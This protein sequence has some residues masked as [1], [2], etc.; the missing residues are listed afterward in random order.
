MHWPV[1]FRPARVVTAPVM[2]PPCL[3]RAPMCRVVFP[4]ATRT[5]V[6]LTDYVVLRKF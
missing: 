2:I 5:L 6:S 3:S 1:S 4:A